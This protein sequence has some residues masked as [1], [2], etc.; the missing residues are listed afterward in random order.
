MG[1]DGRRCG[2]DGGQRWS[3]IKSSSF[4]RFYFSSMKDRWR[5]REGVGGEGRVE[6]RHKIVNVN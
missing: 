1:W 3:S 2:G 4:L 6:T 5:P